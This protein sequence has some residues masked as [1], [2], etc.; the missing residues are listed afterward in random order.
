MEADLAPDGRDSA[1]LCPLV[2]AGTEKRCS[3]LRSGGSLSRAP[4]GP[5]NTAIG[6]IVPNAGPSFV[7]LAQGL[8]WFVSTQNASS[9][10]QWRSLMDL[11]AVS[12]RVLAPDL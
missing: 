10:A 7:R 2:S 3:C 8:A 5:R 4:L 1:S 6:A 9:S 12:H 11:L